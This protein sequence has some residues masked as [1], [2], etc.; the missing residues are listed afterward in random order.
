MSEDET[1]IIYEPA[2]TDHWRNLFPN[3]SMLL[4]CQNL[5]PGEE[6]ILTIDRVEYPVTVKDPNGV[7][8]DV[9]LMHFHN[10]NVPMCLSVTKFI[11]LES[12]FGGYT[13]AWRGKSIQIY[14][15]KAKEYGGKGMVDALCIR[16]FIPNMDEDI[17]EYQDSIMNA[18]SEAE[19]KEVYMSIPKHLQPKLNRATNE[20]REEL[21]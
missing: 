11:V 10:C 20:R 15:G 6:L 7:D 9:R 5:N 19:L 12:L 3:K 21:S 4:G 2:I 17:T 8:R 13:N 16:E 14:Q 1:N 18:A